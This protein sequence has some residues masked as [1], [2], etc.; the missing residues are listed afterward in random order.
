M[1]FV[2]Q[3]SDFSIP[4]SLN[5]WLYRQILEY[6]VYFMEWRKMFFICV[7]LCIVFVFV[8]V[9]AWSLLFTL[10]VFWWN[11]LSFQYIFLST[12]FF[13]FFVSNR[14]VYYLTLKPKSC[15]FLYIHKLNY[16]LQIF[17]NFFIQK[18]Y[19]TSSFG[20]YAILCIQNLYYRYTQMYKQIYLEQIY[21]VT[22]ITSIV[23]DKNV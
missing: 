20:F 2:K 13:W 11:Y 3:T 10:S 6:Y 8:S 22:T 21:L 4:I 18:N 9:C 17:L 5:G 7:S 12:F 16:N 15:Y 19:M 1:V 14:R 23:F